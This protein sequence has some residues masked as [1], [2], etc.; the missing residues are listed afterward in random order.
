MK[1]IKKIIFF[2][3]MFCFL[4][5]FASAEEKV[6]L[7]LFYG[8]GC[9]HC[10]SEKEFLEQIEPN[11]EQ[12]E[13]HLYEVWSNEENQEL[14]GKVKEALNIDQ[15]GVPVTVIGTDYFV[16]YNQDTATKI[17]EK[18]KNYQNEEN[19]VANILSDSEYYQKNEIV[20]DKEEDTSLDL[21]ILGKVDGKSVSLPLLAAVIGFVDG[22][23]PCAMWVLLLLISMLMGMKD[24]KRMWTLGLTFLFTSAFVYFLFM[25]SWLK[26]TAQI[27]QIIL[28]RNV[29]AIVA[30]IAGIINLMKY[31]KE[32]KKDEGCD[33]VDSKKRKKYIQKIKK[34]TTE[35][36][37]FLSLIGIITL[38]F[39]VNLVELACSAGLP[40]LFTQ[41][42]AMNDLN[43]FQYYFY[44]ILYILFFLIDDLIVFFIA[45]KS[46]KLK[47][48]SKKYGNLSHLIGGIIMALIGILLLVKPEW[49]MFNF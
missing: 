25:V 18:I 41:V 12:L 29:I 20:I 9:P 22:F 46:L 23:N 42:L 3:V 17:E 26:I 44:I 21:P 47:G 11:Y 48:F 13:V 38:A 19:V 30:L 35:K 36:S 2:M 43:S 34:F 16:G 8:S 15:S 39:S 5:P 28:V 24:R 49:I 31:A 40:L 27:S 32:S 7:Y 45:M 6:D 33:L 1:Q 14:L 37:L 4:I 10:A